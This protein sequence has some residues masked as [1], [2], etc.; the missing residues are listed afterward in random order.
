KLRD[1]PLP[2]LRLQQDP[3]DLAAVYQHVVRPFVGQ[4]IEPAGD[5]VERLADGQRRHETELRRPTYGV[6]RA[7][8]QRSVEIPPRRGPNSS[9]APAT[10]SL[11]ERLH[12]RSF[13]R[14]LARPSLCFVVGAV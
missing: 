5:R 7:Q 13:L 3:G 2:Q 10:G 1:L 8:D 14:T 12:Q 6:A 4:P 11:L 9:A